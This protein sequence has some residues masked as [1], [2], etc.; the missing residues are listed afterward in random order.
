MGD[1]GLTFITNSLSPHRNAAKGDSLPPVL[2]LLEKRQ[3]VADADRALQD[4]KKVRSTETSEVPRVLGNGG[5]SSLLT[6][7]VRDGL[8]C[9]LRPWPL[10]E[11]EG[12]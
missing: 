3:E 8:C 2:S 1:P 7:E 9:Y 11:S 6:H 12:G 5:P 4:Q 10:P